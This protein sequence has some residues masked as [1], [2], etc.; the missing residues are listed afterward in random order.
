MLLVDRGEPARAAGFLSQAARTGCI[1]SPRSIR[2]ALFR[3]RPAGTSGP[4]VELVW[5]EA[6]RKLIGPRIAELDELLAKEPDRS[7]ELLERAEVTR[8]RLGCMRT[9]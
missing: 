1:S 8:S 9:R 2:A 7:A 4:S 3:P 5:H 6:A